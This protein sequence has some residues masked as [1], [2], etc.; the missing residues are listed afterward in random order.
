MDAASIVLVLLAAGVNFGWQ[1]AD[2]GSDGYEYIVQVEPEVLDVLRR[3]GRVPIESHVPPEVG[4]IRKVSIVVGRGDVPR[5]TITAVQQTAYFA[6]ENGWTAGAP[7][8]APPPGASAYDRYAAPSTGSTIGVSP[9]PSVL[10]R[11]QAAVTETGNTLREGIETGV[12]TAD[13]QFSRAGAEMLDATRNAGQEFGQQLQEFARNPSQQLQSTANDLR[14]ATQQTLGA[15]D[16][17]LQRVNPFATSDAQGA[18]GG[19]SQRAVAPP[20]SWPSSAGH[21]STL[22]ATSATGETGLRGTESP[23]MAP[24]RTA[25]GWTSIGTNV[26]P[27]P[28]AAPQLA[29]SSAS[30]GENGFPIRMA[31]NNGPSFPASDARGVNGSIT[32]P[33]QQQVQA[34]PSASNWANGWSDAAGPVGATIGRSGNAPLNGN[35]SSESNLEAVQP[36]P[37]SQNSQR[38]ASTWDD[39][40]QRNEQVVQ[41]PRSA[42]ANGGT[43]NDPHHAAA[44]Q[45]AGAEWQFGDWPPQSQSGTPRGQVRSSTSGNAFGSIPPDGTTNSGHL[46]ASS[47]STEQPPWLPLLVVS[48]SLVGS[49]SANLFLGWSYIDARQKY[50]TLVRKTADTFRRVAAPAA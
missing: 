10:E 19:N 26:A 36:L 15:V 31:G 23:G 29:S 13:Q 6:G 2:N 46:T 8:A 5:D 34:P 20:P 16:N 49:L 25:T 37:G 32:G 12:Q 42:P 7:N 22:P 41:A 28:L 47:P 11:A 24:T 48:L 1:P 17:E 30:R 14:V 9:P 18:G 45:N 3:G 27:P 50:R 43:R 4:P 39:P 35:G 44:T 33:A 38:A 40:W 21:G